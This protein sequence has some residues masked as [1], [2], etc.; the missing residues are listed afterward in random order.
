M[1]KRKILLF[2]LICSLFSYTAIQAQVAF[3]PLVEEIM[4]GST[5]ETIL[6]LEEPITGNVP[7]IIDGEEYT[8][9]TRNAF[10]EG[11][12]MAAQWIFERFEEYGYEP[13]YHEYDNNGT[14]VLA[15]KTGTMYPDQ[16][17]IICAHYDD[18]P[19]GPTAPGADDNASGTVAVLEAARLLAEHD[20]K[21]TVIFALWDEEEYGLIGSDY[22]AEE[23]SS[24]GDDIKGVLN[25]DMIA[26]ETQ[27]D[28]NVS[29]STN[30][31][32][33]G[34]TSDFVDILEVYTPEVTPN[35]ISSTAS[36]HASFWDEGYP[37]ILVIED[38]SDFNDYYHTVDDDLD[39]LN[40]DY[41]EMLTRAAIAGISTFAMD[42]IVEMYHEPLLSGPETGGREA[43]LITDSTHTY[44]SGM[45]APRLYYRVDGGEF[46]FVN[47]AQ[48]N[49]DTINF[50]IPGQS[51]GSEVEYY[52]ALQGQED[53]FVAT[54]PVGGAGINP[55]GTDSPGEFY[56]YLVDEIYYMET[57]T[58]TLPK[59][60]T[61]NETTYDTINTQG[62]GTIM[63]VNVIINIEH[64]YDGDLNLVL[65]GPGADPRALSL[66]NGGSGD[67][68]INTIFD[69]EA[70][71]SIQEGSAPFTG[72][73]QPQ[74]SLSV[75]DGE[76][77]AGQWVFWVTDTGY[78][79]EGTFNSWCV[80]LQYEP[81]LTTG[82]GQT[83]S[84]NRDL[85]VY[86]VPAKDRL[87]LDFYIEKESGARI[88]IK[89]MSGKTVKTLADRNFNH[90]HYQIHTSVSDLT[91]GQ[92]ILVIT[93]DQKREAKKFVVNK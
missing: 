24:N 8:I 44:A 57:C 93:T 18:M 74:Q 64:E 48:S 37:A 19:S 70:D 1:D 25:F 27:G 89:D 60:V 92:Y 34:L 38:M 65:E 41:F 80:I 17:Y 73:Y 28:Y 46:D 42:Y 43:V 9:E 71:Q 86:P 58:N 31:L 13:W 62:S 50:L 63:D 45:D 36:D 87:T 67:G 4:N 51:M 66:G 91:S 54:L 61:D 52:F 56:S 20:T 90:G 16:Q 81:G 12:A 32:S 29:I 11:N 88:D 26:W 39:I 83:G 6:E 14:N 82:A 55:P 15:Q 68:Y 7:A 85:R 10:Q 22:Y 23:A 76:S 59:A 69:D 84:P 75:F 2:A 3:S 78:G 79:D 53:D 5:Q 49:G 47:P 30:T 40:M 21:Y 72:A 33:S 77:M 35:Y